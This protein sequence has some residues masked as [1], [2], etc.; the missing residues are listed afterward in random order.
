MHFI[1]KTVKRKL[2]KKLRTPNP[3]L[4]ENSVST[5]HFP[6][7]A[8]NYDRRGVNFERCIIYIY[9]KTLTE[10]FLRRIT[11]IQEIIWLNDVE[12]YLIKTASRQTSNNASLNLVL[13]LQEIVLQFVKTRSELFLIRITLAE[14]SWMFSLS[15]RWK[16]ENYTA[17]SVRQ[18]DQKLNVTEKHSRALLSTFQNRMETVEWRA[19]DFARNPRDVDET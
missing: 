7:I 2:K 18:D 10:L 16:S 5:L 8:R 17:L 15:V 6:I 4:R 1:I 13:K 14:L 12:Y 9:C 11:Y 19:R 3:N